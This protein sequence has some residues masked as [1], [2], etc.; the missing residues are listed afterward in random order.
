LTAIVT[1]NKSDREAN[2]GI[3]N[4]QKEFKN[5]NIRKM[6]AQQLIMHSNISIIV[7]CNPQIEEDIKYETEIKKCKIETIILGPYSI[8]NTPVDAKHPKRL[9]QDVQQYDQT[10]IGY[11]FLFQL[12]QCLG[13]QKY[14]IKYEGLKIRLFFFSKSCKSTIKICI[15]GANY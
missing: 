3:Y 15:F 4:G 1:N 8:L 12:Q 6:F 2:D 5:N 11:K 14:V 13:S 9:N 7:I 10:K